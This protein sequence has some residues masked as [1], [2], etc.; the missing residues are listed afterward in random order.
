M[1]EAF[2]KDA[3]PRLQVEWVVLSEEMC[4]L[5]SC[6]LSSTSRNLVLEELRVKRVAVILEEICCRAF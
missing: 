4:I 2:I 3:K 1:V 6:L 5:A